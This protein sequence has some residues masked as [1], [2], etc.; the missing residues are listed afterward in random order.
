VP[1][2]FTP[3]TEEHEIG[4]PSLERLITFLFDGGVHGLFMLVE[5]LRSDDGALQ[6]ARPGRASGRDDRPVLAD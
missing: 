2:E 3:S 4:V 6:R 5:R 1:S